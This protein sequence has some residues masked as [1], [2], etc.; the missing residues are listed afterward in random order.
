MEADAIQ[1]LKVYLRNP[2]E[3]EVPDKLPA[4]PNLDY[5]VDRFCFA[6]IRTRTQIFDTEI[7][8]YRSE[9]T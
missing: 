4:V 5:A 8:L 2:R 6:Y 9:E 7:P 3:R 1:R